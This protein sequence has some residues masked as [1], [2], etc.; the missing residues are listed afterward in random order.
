M[1]GDFTQRGEPA[2]YDKFIRTRL[3]LACGADIVLEMPVAAATASARD[4]ARTGVALLAASGAGKLSCL[5]L[6]RCKPSA[7]LFSCRCTV[8]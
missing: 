8:R 1:S 2:I 5:W 6:R 3:A 7:A 4:F